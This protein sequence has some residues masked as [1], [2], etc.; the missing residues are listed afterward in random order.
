MNAHQKW[1]LPAAYKIADFELENMD[2]GKNN[3]KMVIW[4]EGCLTGPLNLM[5]ESHFQ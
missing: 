4:T 3:E 2:F 5:A 1:W